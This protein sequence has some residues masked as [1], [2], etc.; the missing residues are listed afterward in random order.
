[1]DRSLMLEPVDGAVGSGLVKV[2]RS[3]LRLTTGPSKGSK[4]KLALVMAGGSEAIV[5]G[6]TLLKVTS[7]RVTRLGSAWRLETLTISGRGSA[8]MSAVTAWPTLME[9]V[10]SGVIDSEKS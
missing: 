6:G 9:K 4:L 1:M 8:G 10:S 5:E 7:T 3:P 2:K